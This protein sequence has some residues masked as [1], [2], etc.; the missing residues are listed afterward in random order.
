MP[1]QSKS[2]ARQHV[3]TKT[4]GNAVISVTKTTSIPPP[5][6]PANATPPFSNQFRSVV[7]NTQN[8]RPCIPVCSSTTPPFLN[9]GQNAWTGVV[10]AGKVPANV[11]RPS[12]PICSSSAL[13][14]STVSARIVSTTTPE[15]SPISRQLFPA[16]KKSSLQPGST[17]ATKTTVSYTMAVIA[18]GKSSKTVPANVV[19]VSTKVTTTS[20]TKVSTISPI[21]IERAGS[22]PPS[23]AVVHTQ[24]PL[25]HSSCSGPST[26][27]PFASNHSAKVSGSSASQQS[28]TVP[29]S[30][31]HITQAPV[32]SKPFLNPAVSTSQNAV[33]NNASSMSPSGSQ[34]VTSVHSSIAQ[35]YTPFNNIFAKV[36]QSVWGQKDKETSKP[37]FASVAAS[38]V[39]SV[40]SPVQNSNPVQSSLTLSLPLNSESDLIVDAAK[41]PGYRG[42]LH[43]SPSASSSSPASSNTPQIGISNS[44][45]GPI[46]SGPRSAPCTPPLGPIGPPSSAASSTRRST[47][48]AVPSPPPPPHLSRSLPESQNVPLNE[49]PRSVTG[50]CSGLPPPH[51]SSQVSE[52]IFHHQN[53]E[54]SFHPNRLQSFPMAATLASPGGTNTTYS[55]HSPLSS[56]GAIL[57]DGGNNGPMQVVQSNL[58]PNA[59]DFSS[60]NS[61]LM[62]SQGPPLH[63]LPRLPSGPNNFQENSVPP[64]L[65]QFRPILT[66]GGGMNHN[67][68]LHAVANAQA[69]A[70]INR[71]PFH[72]VPNHQQQTTDFNNPNGS[73]GTMGSVVSGLSQGAESMPL[74]SMVAG[75]PHPSTV[76]PGNGSIPHHYPGLQ[77]MMGIRPNQRSASTT[78]SVG[79]SSKGKLFSCAVFRI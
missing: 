25:S 35:E 50:G 47:P 76:V 21:S 22:A 58:N 37:N 18:Q 65:T 73:T 3:V 24:M 20:D 23:S 45:F 14:V 67:F 26:V 66:S 39:T 4:S 9:N 48:P 8:I 56:V 41:A 61:L 70:A 38:G 15:K 49:M 16:E 44:N 13:S 32:Q 36:A 29:V 17:T 54:M 46:G 19:T 53:L 63:H 57:L 30:R 31:I 75:Y 52:A 77:S 51:M 1:S 55:Q 72:H 40:A 64:H 33:S 10:V 62:T 74:L 43:I 11:P 68:P 69:Q 28:S 34:T 7:T 42:N 12:V 2:I 71:F 6:L 5:S 27:Q 59:P 78:P 79:T 60:R